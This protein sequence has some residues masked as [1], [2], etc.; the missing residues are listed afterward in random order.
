M[1]DLGSIYHQFKK[2]NRLLAINRPQRFHHFFD[3]FIFA[4]CYLRSESINLFFV[5][6]LHVVNLCFVAVNSIC[7]LVLHVVKKLSGSSHFNPHLMHYC[8]FLKKPWNLIKCFSLCVVWKYNRTC[9]R[10]ISDVTF[11]N[12]FKSSDR[13]WPIPFSNCSSQLPNNL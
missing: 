5:H 11:G 9:F 8:C 4:L 12:M 7:K 3:F 2:S 1:Y 13:H 6:Q 10:Y